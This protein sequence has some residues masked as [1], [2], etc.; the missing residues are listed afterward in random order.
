MADI[1]I[2]GIG[3]PYR[4]DDASGWAVIDGLMKKVEMGSVIRLVK[5][6]GDIAELIDLFG[7]YKTVYLVDACRSHAPNGTWRRIDVQKEPILEENP[8]T[9][10][11]GFSVSQA[12]SLAK[13]L[14]Q[15]PNKLILY[16]ISSDSYTISDTFSPCVAKSV[17]LVVEAILNE[18]DVQV[19]MNR[20]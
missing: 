20:A 11:H 1:I 14:G 4:G 10:T 9:S 2:V 16:V 6:R 19:C 12:I 18:E 17:D 7:Q 5:Q 13:N 3:N 15:L 8:Q